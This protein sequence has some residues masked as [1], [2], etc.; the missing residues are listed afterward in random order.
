MSDAETRRRG[1]GELEPGVL[2]NR[3]S[4]RYAGVC[5]VKNAHRVRFPTALAATPTGTVRG[6][7]T[8]SFSRGSRTESAFRLRAIDTRCDF[9]GFRLI[10]NDKT[11]PVATATDCVFLSV[12]D[13]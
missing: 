8:V 13:S 10:R 7:V 2:N 6:Q 3:Q 1:R 11:Q 4:G 9:A 12:V 5:R